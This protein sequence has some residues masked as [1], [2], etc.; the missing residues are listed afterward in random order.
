MIKRNNLVDDKKWKLTG[1]LLL[2][3]IS[4]VKND[5]KHT[6]TIVVGEKEYA[7]IKE[8]RLTTEGKWW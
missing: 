2:F 6:Y 1:P 7:H 8:Y 4:L 3:L 5:F